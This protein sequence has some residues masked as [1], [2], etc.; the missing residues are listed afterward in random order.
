ME[1]YSSQERK[2]YHKGGKILRYEPNNYNEINSSRF[3]KKCFEDV[4]CVEFCKRVCEVSF[5]EHLIDWIAM[6]LKGERAIIEGDEFKFS[7]VSISLATGI[8]N[9]GEY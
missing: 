6:Y 3:I 8:P 7:L 4:N 9:H 2:N 5:H 1:G